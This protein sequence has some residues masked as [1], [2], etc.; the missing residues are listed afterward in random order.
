[1][2]GSMTH[3]S[4]LLSTSGEIALAGG[5][6]DLAEEYFTKGLE[7]AREV[8]ILE[9]I[10]GHLANLGRVAIRR[11][12]QPLT[13]QRLTAL[14]QQAQAVGARHLEVRIRLWLAPLEPPAEA[15]RLL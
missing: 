9:R 4:Y 7:L 5:E 12:D 13:R 2:R 14:L 8:P 11:G 1:A 6:L 3:L 10:A 15:A